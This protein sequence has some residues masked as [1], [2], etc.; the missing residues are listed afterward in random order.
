MPPFKFVLAEFKAK[1]ERRG[2]SDGEGEGVNE[3]HVRAGVEGCD[4]THAVHVREHIVQVREEHLSS[5][6]LNWEE[7]EH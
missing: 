5:L 7:K 3:P 6:A 1:A 4:G 2:E